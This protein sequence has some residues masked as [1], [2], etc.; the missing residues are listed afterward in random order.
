MGQDAGGLWR[1]DAH[2]ENLSAQLN[3]VGLVAMAMGL[4]AVVGFEREVNDKP[5]GLRTHML[6][7]GACC[8]IALIGEIAFEQFTGLG[9][10][11]TRTLHGIVTGIGF[12]GAGSIIKGEGGRTEGLTT[13]ASVLFVAVVGAAVAYGYWV[14]AL[15]ATLL[16][17]ATLT[18]LRL[19]VRLGVHGEDQDHHRRG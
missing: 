15:G 1:T 5:A 14:L 7:A 13:A 19:L 11:P 3:M 10:D 12:L 16:S 9:G 18:L 4:G 8:L 2:V 6:V 17:V